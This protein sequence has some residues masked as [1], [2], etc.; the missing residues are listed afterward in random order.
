M[1]TSDPKNGCNC[2]Q[3][4]AVPPLLDGSV[5]QANGCALAPHPKPIM[6]NSDMATNFPISGEAGVKNVVSNG[7]GT[8]NNIGKGDVGELCAP[9]AVVGN[10]VMTPA[11]N[12]RLNVNEA[13]S[14]THLTF[15]QPALAAGST[16]S[17]QGFGCVKNSV[18]NP[19]NNINKQN[20]Q[21]LG[22]SLLPKDPNNAA[23]SLWATVQSFMTIGIPNSCINGISVYNNPL[24]GPKNPYTFATQSAIP[25]YGQYSGSVA[26]PFTY[27]DSNNKRFIGQNKLN[28]LPTASVCTAATPP[29]GE[30]RDNFYREFEVAWTKMVTSGFKYS[31]TFTSYR[32][33]NGAQSTVTVQYTAPGNGK[34]GQLFDISFTNKR[35]TSSDIASGQKQWNT[36]LPLMTLPPAAALVGSS[37]CHIGEGQN[38]GTC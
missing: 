25:N 21:T 26:A 36:A 31:K 15:P 23:V 12:G 9:F 38:T 4:F 16:V 10:A 17:Q 32:V 35:Q 7:V 2:A 11:A 28:G 34:L 20:T 1:K 19:A 30:G 13:T 8:I 37:T 6:L 5:L 27:S 18:G 29:L 33:M 24:D 22:S 14:N 3:F